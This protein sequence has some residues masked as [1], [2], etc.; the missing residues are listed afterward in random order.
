MTT[1]GWGLAAFFALPMF[2]LFHVT[3]PTDPRSPFYNKTV[4]ESKF[5]TR[6]MSHRQAFL[7]YIAFINC[8]IPLIIIAVCYFRIFLK[9]AEKANESK[10]GN[11]KKQS[12]KPGKVHLQSTPSS[13][14]PKAKIKTL[15]M[16]IAILSA[17]IICNLPLNIIEM[18][19]SYGDHTAVPMIVY[20]IVGSM[21]PANSAI[22]PWVFLAFNA[23]M[24][25]VRRVGKA[26]PWVKSRD[27]RIY[28]ES[29]MSTR[30][31]FTM[32]TEVP[33]SAAC[34]T[35]TPDVVEMTSVKNNTHAQCRRTDKKNV[36]YTSM[37]ECE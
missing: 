8:F 20:G 6:P 36:T 29:T 19:F 35:Y 3:S 18:I 10:A 33:A 23:N 32:N 12:I 7:T 14:L 13:S 25:C 37:T 9:I 1:V 24:A 5:R 27:A 30:S 26:L 2:E 31:E 22:N 16:T 17:F 28:L 34:N 11:Q 15:K 4:C 21:A